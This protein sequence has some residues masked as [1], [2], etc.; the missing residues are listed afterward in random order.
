MSVSLTLCEKNTSKCD[1]SLNPELL[2]FMIMVLTPCRFK[3]SA[4]L[5]RILLHFCSMRGLLLLIYIL[6]VVYIS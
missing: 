5:I 2:C 3:D 4:E 6:E 1:D